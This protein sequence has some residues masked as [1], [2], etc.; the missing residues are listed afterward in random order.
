MWS[1]NN[2]PNKASGE[3]MIAAVDV[4]GTKIGVGMVDSAGRRAVA[5]SIADGT[6]QRARERA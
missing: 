1:G 3:K 4:G 6:R 5:G 2:D